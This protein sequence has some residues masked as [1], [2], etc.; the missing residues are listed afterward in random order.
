MARIFT[1]YQPQATILFI[2]YSG[3]E[4]GLYGSEAHVAELTASGDLGKI[5]AMLDMDM[6]GYTVR[7]R[8]RLPSRD[9]HHSPRLCSTRLSTPL[10]NY[11][12]LR[13]VTTL[14]AWGSDH[15]PYLDAG[16]PALLTIEYDYGDY[17]DYHRT[18]DV[19][20]NLTIAMA[21]ETLKMNVAALAVLT[22]TDPTRIFVDGFE[23]RRHFVVEHRLA[24]TT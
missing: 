12:Q 21:E 5:Q 14:N 17:P 16:V 6:I 18:T 2:C 4:Q 11:T 7:C 24:L 15:V 9:R 1:A 19:P 20:A 8:S 22:D 10:V 23:I 3:E 13:I